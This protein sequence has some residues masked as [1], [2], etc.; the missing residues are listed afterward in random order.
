MKTMAMYISD[1]EGNILQKWHIGEELYPGSVS[2][3]WLIHADCD[4]LEFLI[5]QF[6]SLPFYNPSKRV[7]IVKGEVAQ[8]ILMNMGVKTRK[9]VT[10]SAE[11]RAEFLKGMEP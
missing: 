2:F 4:E 9:P 7:W 5:D 3:G 8:N 10:L 1:E 11:E 6:G